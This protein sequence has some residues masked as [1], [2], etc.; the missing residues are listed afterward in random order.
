M[1]QQRS[2]QRPFKG[3]NRSL[4]QRLN[5][6]GEPALAFAPTA[7]VSGVLAFVEVLSQ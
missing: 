2:S 5:W 7:V 3:A 6:R 1:G 4:R